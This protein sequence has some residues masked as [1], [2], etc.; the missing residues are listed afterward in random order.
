M[1]TPVRTTVLKI[2]SEYD[3][4]NKRLYLYYMKIATFGI[5]NNS[6]FFVKFLVF[7]QPYNESSLILFQIETVPVPTL[8][9]NAH[10]DSCAEV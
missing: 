4:A 8:N 5:D 7:V 3:L 6:D 2:K 1:I 9:Q 10:A